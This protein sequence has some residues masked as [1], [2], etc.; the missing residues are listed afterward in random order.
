M[1]FLS[2]L[3]FFAGLILLVAGAESLV[4]GASRSAALLGISPLVIGLTVVAFATSSPEMTVCIHSALAGKG[5]IAVGNVVGS[6]ILNILLILGLSATIIPLAVSRQLIRFDLPV[7]IFSSLVMY[8]FSLD[9]RITFFE[10]WILIGGIVLYTFYS[11]VRSRKSRRGGYGAGSD[12][13]EKQRRLS[14]RALFPYFLLVLFGLGFLIAGSHLMIRGATDIARHLKVSEL[15]IGLTIIAAGTSLPEAATSIV[16]SIRGERDIAVG[17]AVGS[18]IFNILAALGL[19]ALSSPGGVQVT[20]KAFHFDIPIMFMVALFCLPVFYSD[21]TID[22]RE[23][24][25]FLL[26]YCAYTIYLILS[27][28]GSEI[29]PFFS[30]ITLF[31]VIPATLL[32]WLFTFFRSSVGIRGGK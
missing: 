15:V 5:D 20:S 2:I 19:T 3:Y 30:R 6:N 16:A 11:V 9:G 32:F 12:T 27:S 28:T 22:R 10:G 23:G 31:V 17:N 8:I 21:F 18:N 29:L 24:I 4:R 7:M 14:P 1:V 25:L 26:Y 13:P